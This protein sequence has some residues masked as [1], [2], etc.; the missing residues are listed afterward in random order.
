MTQPEDWYH[1]TENI[2]AQLRKHGDVTLEGCRYKVLL[3]WD[4]P[5]EGY[6]GHIPEIRLYVRGWAL[7]RVLEALGREANR[8]DWAAESDLVM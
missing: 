7:R 3:R 5:D 4:G 6:L 2:E 1:D 8:Y